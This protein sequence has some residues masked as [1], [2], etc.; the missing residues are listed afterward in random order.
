MHS[1]QSPDSKHKPAVPGVWYLFTDWSNRRPTRTEQGS[2][3]QDEEQEGSA[4]LAN[5]HRQ[6][7]INT[8]IWLCRGGWRAFTVCRCSCIKQNHSSSIWR[9]MTTFLRRTDVLP[10]RILYY[11]YPEWQQHNTVSG[12]WQLFE[13]RKEPLVNG[14]GQAKWEPDLWE[15]A[16]CF[17]V[18]IH[19]LHSLISSMRF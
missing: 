2:R 6:L 9:G 12:R 16:F 15:S 13:M 1:P 10:L 4:M 18:S 17:A 3:K 14:E 5:C 19:L 11:V 7:E 8:D